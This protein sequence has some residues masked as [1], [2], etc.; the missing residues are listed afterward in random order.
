MILS[1]FPNLLIRPLNAMA[2]KYFDSNLAINGYNVSGSFGN[3]NGN[4]IMLVTM[5]VFIVPLLFL[6]LYIGKVTKVKQ[7]NIVYAAERPESP[8]TTHVAHN[9]YA[10]Y[11]K[12][13]GGWGKP[14]ILDFWNAS[15]EWTHTMADLFRRIY[16][17]N[18]QTYLLHIILFFVLVFFFLGV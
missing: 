1:S 7:F 8:Q 10:H 6:I 4:L 2:G 9:M 14:R 12:A 18:G 17:G 5:G 16:S 13:L 3:W 15:A 11:R